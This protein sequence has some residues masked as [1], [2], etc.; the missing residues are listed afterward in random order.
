[1]IDK[2]GANQ[3]SAP[4]PAGVDSIRDSMESANLR[5]KQADSASVG[6]AGPSRDPLDVS[7][8]VDYGTLI[9][10]AKSAEA[11]PRADAEAVTEARELLLSGQLETPENIRSAAENIVRLGV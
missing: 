2:I 7:L 3:G 6:N 9:E 1:M 5:T 11:D 8:Q 10:E 4:L